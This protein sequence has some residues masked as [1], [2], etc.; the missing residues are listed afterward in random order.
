MEVRTKRLV[1]FGQKKDRFPV[2]NDNMDFYTDAQSD[3]GGCLC[4]LFPN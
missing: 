3:G 1:V 4:Q 2:D